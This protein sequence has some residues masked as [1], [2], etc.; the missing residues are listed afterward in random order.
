MYFHHLSLIVVSNSLWP[1][2]LYSLSN[3]RGQNTGVG[4]LSLL[5]GIFPTFLGFEPRSP[6]LQA[7]S[8]PAE[9]QGKLSIDRLCIFTTS[10]YYLLLLLGPYCFCP[11]L[12]PSL[13]EMFPW[14]LSFSFFLFWLIFIFYR[15]RVDFCCACFTFM[16]TWFSY[17][18]MYIYSAYPGDFPV[19]FGSSTGII[20]VVINSVFLFTATSQGLP[21]TT[22]IFLSHKLGF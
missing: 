9:P 15:S 14:Y 3:S 22:F 2:G 11:F 20:Y 6:A 8:L 16:R 5:Q 18:Q 21:A 12:C 10:P 7:D 13:H 4:S 19:L 17:T 1:H